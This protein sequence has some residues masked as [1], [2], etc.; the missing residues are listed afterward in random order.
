MICCCSEKQILLAIKKAS[1]FVGGEVWPG[2]SGEEDQ[3]RRLP[4][5]RVWPADRGRRPWSERLRQA[6][7]EYIKKKAHVCLYFYL[8]R[9]VM[10]WF[11]Q[12][13]TLLD[14][15]LKLFNIILT[16]DITKFLFVQPQC[17]RCHSLE[18][19]H[20]LLDCD[21][22]EQEFQKIFFNKVRKWWNI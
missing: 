6:G 9:L 3:P 13:M 12:Y 20:F 8:T 18:V 15:C 2:I 21:D 10:P 22:E 19:C 5:G 4:D 16:V 11:V 17:S 7:K 14:K 1:L